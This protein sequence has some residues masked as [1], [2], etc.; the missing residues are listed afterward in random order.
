MVNLSRFF[1]VAAE[2]M[3][4]YTNRKFIKRFQY[5]E[6]KLKNEGRKLEDC[7]LEKDG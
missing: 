1:N 4:R 2:D 7:S 5:I 6:Q 3:L